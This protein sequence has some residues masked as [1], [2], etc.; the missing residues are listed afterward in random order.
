MNIAEKMELES[1]LMMNI[2]SWMQE[3]GE[4]LSDRQQSN[5]YTGVRIREI[6]WRGYTFRI[7]DVD[8]MTCQIERL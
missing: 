6:R 4:V 5:A 1:R 2:A 7:V 3:H 8:G